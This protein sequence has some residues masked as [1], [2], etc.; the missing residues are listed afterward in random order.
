M[1]SH[2]E[3]EPEKALAVAAYLADRT[4]ETM[5][6]I[7]KMIYVVDRLHLERYGRP[8]TG[9]DFIAMEQGACPSKIYDSMKALRGE[10]KKNWLPESE[11]FLKVD[12]ETFDVDV[13]DM[14]SLDV[15]SESDIECLDAVISALKRKGRWHI[16]RLAHDSAWKAT[17][18]NKPMDLITIAES[19]NDGAMVAKHLQE[20]FQ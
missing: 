19:L 2:F 10:H 1:P 14:P 6:T 18:R 5:Y 15:L 17:D 11:R 4:G 20:R 8:V 12:P 9:D 3:F 7:L 16:R 13:F